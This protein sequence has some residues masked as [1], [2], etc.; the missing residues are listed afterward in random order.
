M[1][2]AEETRKDLLTT[3]TKDKLGD[4][5]ART[6]GREDVREP[7]EVSRETD[8]GR[9]PEEVVRGREEP[10]DGLLGGREAKEV[11][12]KKWKVTTE[13]VEGE[14]IVRELTLEEIAEHGLLD[15]IIL[16]AN[17][18]P[19]IQRKYQD[20]L[21]RAAAG[22]DGEKRAEVAPVKPAPPTQDQIRNAYSMVLKDTVARGF[23]EPDF[24]EAYPDVGTN[25][26][27]FRDMMEEV[28][29]KLGHVIDWIQSEAG[30]RNAT[31]VKGMLDS[32]ID[33]IA[34]RSDGD[35]GDPL[36]KSLRDPE[37]RAGFIKW[38]R[39]EVDPKVGALTE[40]NMEKFWFAFNAKEIVSYTKE[41]A[42][43]ASK[44]SVKP[45]PRA[46]SDGTPV[47]QGQPVTEQATTLLDRM[48]NRA[49]EPE[50]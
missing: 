40:A 12:P 36:F 48:T 47:R 14:S 35:K 7:G 49:L 5:P 18:F 8:V 25:L 34:A 11:A 46:A 41:A 17:Q 33:T 30:M 9:R 45:R 16:T 2:Q 32:V 27:Y 15:K 42:E 13:G 22:K 24:A 21:E 28:Q 43:K 20:V 1:A 4:V 37:V 44:S 50:A 19:G 10:G 29:E 39:D 23:I 26:M 6:D 31:K 3:F 38:L